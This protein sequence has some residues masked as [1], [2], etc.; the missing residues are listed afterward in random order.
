MSEKVPLHSELN[1]TSFM[2]E[3]THNPLFYTRVPGHL[4]F[5]FLFHIFYQIINL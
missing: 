2:T 4:N 3:A 5:H 1:L